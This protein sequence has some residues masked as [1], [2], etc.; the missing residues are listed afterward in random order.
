MSSPYL[1]LMARIPV[2]ASKTEIG[3][4]RLKEAQ[5][6]VGLSDE[7]VARLIHVSTKTWWRWRRSGTVPTVHLPAVAKALRL[8]FHDEPTVLERSSAEEDG[9]AL[10][11][12]RLQ[13]LEG[14]VEEQISLTR[15]ALELLDA[16]QVAAAP[17]TRKRASG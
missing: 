5:N 13:S 12:S 8:E 6:R 15:R 17:P 9:L 7:A 14:L 2:V 10:I 4:E 16:Q 3:P 11:A 1:D